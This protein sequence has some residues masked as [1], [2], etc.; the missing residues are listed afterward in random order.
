MILN[1][2]QIIELCEEQGM[3]T[4]FL[5]EKISHGV[6][7]YGLSS[8]GYDIRIAKKFKVFTNVYCSIVDPKKFDPRAMTDI[9]SED[10][11]LIPPNSFALGMS[12]EY[13]QMPA[14]VIGIC[15]G[16]STYARAGIIVNVTPINPGWRGYLTIEISNTTPLPAR[17]YVGEGIAQVIFLRGEPCLRTY[18]GKYQ[19]QEDIVP[20]RV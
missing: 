10:L 3:I 20:A 13:F 14:D 11:I 5:R 12:V 8:Y 16:K 4:P 17:I 19:N 7:S 1:D 6:I 15:I 9:I 18:A 2:K